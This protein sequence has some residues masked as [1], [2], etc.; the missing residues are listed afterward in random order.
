MIILFLNIFLVF[1][2]TVNMDTSD[3]P[4]NIYIR[5]N[6]LGYLPGESKI[7]IAFSH[8]AIKEKFLLISDDSKSSITALKPKRS[9]SKGWGTFNY[10]YEIDFSQIELPG[11]YFLQGQ[12]SKSKS[13]TFNISPKA[14]QNQTENLLGFMR[15]QRCGYNPFL[16]VVCHQKDGRSMFGPMPDS[17]FVDVSGGWHDAGDQLKYLITGSY[18]SAHML[19]AFK[20]YPDKFADEVN[21]LG[22]PFP[23]NI[24]DV[25]D[26]A[27]WG[28]DWIH[29][30]HPSPSQLFHQIA[31][32]R[33][34]LGWK[35]PDTD[36][37]DYGWGSNSYRVAYFATGEPQGLREYKSEAT[38]F[39]NLAGRS[40]AAM[41]LAARIWKDHLNDTAY[42]KKCLDA[43]Q[44]LY[45]LG[46]ENEGFQQ[47]NSYGAPYRYTEETWADDMEWGAAELYKTTGKKSYLEKAKRYAILANTVSWMNLDTAAHYQYYPF[48]NLGHFVLFDLVDKNFQDTLV[49]YYRT[50]IDYTF[51][52]AMTNPY[53]IGIPFI[54]CSNNLLTSLI[55]QVI[56]YEKMTSDT[57]YHQFLVEQRDWLF[58]RNPWGTSMFTG[59]PANGEYP[60]DV[61]TSIWALT[62]LE[63]PGG[64]VDGPVFS[65]IYN[66]LQ[67]LT[68]VNPDEFADVQNKYVVYHDDIGDFSTN[69]PTMDGTAGSIIMMAHWAPNI[70]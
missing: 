63:V 62:K 33:D 21:A 61:H 44:S 29:K 32:D 41:A 9:K 56:L 2:Q 57:Q 47:G 37:S 20:L 49:G 60:I 42:S 5:V 52:K 10:Y 66:S 8:A 16:D 15:Q 24:P 7:A 28:L 65:S 40:A 67:G 17:T 43:A 11:N 3:T 59:I 53:G 22:Q 13:Q 51:K 58:G 23:N 18:A 4:G 54:W 35:M 25:L 12:K 27:K 30:L 69:E 31:D 34:H 14:Y 19:L 55:T 36:P 38:G 6:Q 64:L 48:I 46:R 26:E 1:L 68:L 50:G 45:Q 39:A 70:R